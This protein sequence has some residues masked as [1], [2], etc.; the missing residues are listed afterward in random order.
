VIS[1]S[2][3]ATFVIPCRVSLA[4]AG[5]L[6][7]QL[8]KLTAALAQAGDQ[9]GIS[10][11]ISGNTA[12]VGA[13]TESGAGANSGAAYLFDVTTGNQLFDLSADDAAAGDQF[14]FSVAI[15]GNTAI[16][17]ARLKDGSFAD[18]GAAYLFD[19][20][21]GNQLHKLTADDTKAGDQFGI[22]VA[23]SGNTAVV[24][25]SM[26]DEGG[27]DAGAAYLFD[28][29]TGDQLFKLTADDAAVG[30]RF[31]VSVAISGNTAIV[32]A[33]WDDDAGLNSG[34]A[35]F[36]D[37]T[38]GNQIDKL[39][40]DDA[41]ANDYFGYSVAIS[42]KNAIVG[43]YWDDDA[44][45]RAG[46][47]YLFD[48]ATGT[49]LFELT[50]DDAAAGDIFGY[51]VAIDG[52][53]AI[54]GARFDDD[55]GSACG[56]A[57]LFDVTTG[58][59]LVKLVADDAAEFDNFGY[60]VAISGDRCIAGAPA[61]DDSGDGSGSAYLFEGLTDPPSS[62]PDQPVGFTTAISAQPNPFRTKTTIGFSL[63]EPGSVSLAVWDVRGR[64]VRTLLEGFQPAG[65]GTVSWDG[66]TDWGTRASAGVYFL[67]LSSRDASAL[68]RK[69]VIGR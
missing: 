23:I 56:S 42:G 2:I 63:R 6:G 57:Y 8:V 66:Y 49:Q 58:D 14:G 37:V 29:T 50:A 38:T 28:V 31:G 59:Q 47:A 18:A 5:G 68:T 21:T 13:H 3:A 48:V 16:V 12:V 51:S 44:G 33:Y 34:S 36:F 35:Y 7:D 43:A 22:S 40:A 64:R 52:N 46:S 53:Q 9:F 69:I 54:V 67:R 1:I 41:A 32:G 10:T 19:V 60:S 11:A 17:G 26:N 4:A 24:G 61:D 25:A 55:A 45:T 39:T 27:A 30:D 20:T 62:V 15:S 65:E